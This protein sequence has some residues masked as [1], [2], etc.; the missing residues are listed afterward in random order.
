[1]SQP[2]PNSPGAV[3]IDAN[4]LI[5]ICAKEPNQ[6]TAENAL[7]DYAARGWVFYAPGAILTEAPF[8]LCKKRQDG[9][10]TEVKYREAIEAFNDYMQ[11]ILPSPQG[12]IRFILRAE[13]IRQG[14]S[15]LHTTDAFYLALTEEL[16]ATGAA[17]FVTF[18]KR[19]VNV[20]A[21]NAPAVKVNLLPT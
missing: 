21:K 16:A 11:T 1:M 19:V 17:E 2:T 7:A 5:S 6:Q 10:L 3:V 12:D 9:L 14:Y 4:I 18:D 8:V 15:C 20:A 13:E